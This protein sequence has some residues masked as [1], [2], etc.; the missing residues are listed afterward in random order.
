MS[1]SIDYNHQLSSDPPTVPYDV[2]FVIADENKEQQGEIQGHKFIF[3]HNSSVF[4]IKFYGAGDFADK[5]D[6]EVEVIGSL[7]AFRLMTNFLYNKPTSIANLSVDKIFDVVNLAYC[8]NISMLE[9]ALVRCLGKMVVFKGIVM[10]AATEADKFA[11]IG[12]VS[13]ALLMN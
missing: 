3:A 9:E 8:D 12:R 7:E 13:N 6:K 4:R 1:L 10:E 2:T 5:N 11:M